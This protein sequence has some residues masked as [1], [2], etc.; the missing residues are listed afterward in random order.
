[1]MTIRLKSVRYRLVN[2]VSNLLV[3]LTV[4]NDHAMEKYQEEGLNEQ[5]SCF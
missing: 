3:P 5:R 1:M 4:K 2:M